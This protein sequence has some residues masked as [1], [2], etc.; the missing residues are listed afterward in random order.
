MALRVTAIFPTREAAEHAARTLEKLGAEREQ[1]SVVACRAGPTQGKEPRSRS[2]GGTSAEPVEESPTP[3]TD[4][5][6][7]GVKAVGIGAG[8]GLLAGAAAGGITAALTGIGPLAGAVAATAGFGASL[9]AV[10]RSLGIEE[11]NA[12]HYQ[13]R[14]H[15]GAALLTALV[16]ETRRQQVSASLAEEGAEHVSFVHEPAASAAS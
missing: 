12:R 15:G 9:Y 1:I 8:A 3:E 14:V 4:R 16:P 6:E 11:E 5:Q 7:M 2:P 13:E 10:L